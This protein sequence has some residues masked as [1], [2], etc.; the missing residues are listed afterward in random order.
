MNVMFTFVFWQVKIFVKPSQ[1]KIIKISKNLYSEL[2]KGK[3]VRYILDREKLSLELLKIKAQKAK[4][5][6]A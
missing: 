6:K 5:W 3:N 4:N 2:E 1:I